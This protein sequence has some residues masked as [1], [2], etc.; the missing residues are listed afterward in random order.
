[1]VQR[2]LIIKGE[3]QERPYKVHLTLLGGFLIRCCHYIICTYV[4]VCD[5]YIYIYIVVKMNNP[6]RSKL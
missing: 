5:K 2:A 1:M 4:C 6:C 3:H